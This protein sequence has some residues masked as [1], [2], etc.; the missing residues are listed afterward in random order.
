MIFK[1]HRFNLALLYFLC[2]CDCVTHSQ[3]SVWCVFFVSLKE[4]LES[5]KWILYCRFNFLMTPHIL[6][7]VCWMVCRSAGSVCY[8]LL[9]GRESTLPWFYRSTYW[10]IWFIF[11]RM[12]CIVYVCVFLCDYIID[13]LIMLI[14]WVYLWITCKYICVSLYSFLWGGERG[15]ASQIVCNHIWNC[16]IIFE[17]WFW[18]YLKIQPSLIMI[19]SCS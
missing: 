4:I 14:I 19:W 9:K 10:F 7:L 8:N 1:W 2:L 5:K 6:L 18:V 3:T 17:N 16:E 13:I 15:H 11:L 12:I